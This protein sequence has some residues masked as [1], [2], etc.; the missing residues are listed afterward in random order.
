MF[1][2]TLFQYIIP[3]SVIL[4]THTKIIQIVGQRTARATTV[5]SSRSE[6]TMK[7]NKKTTKVKI[8]LLITLLICHLRRFLLQLRLNARLDPVFS[9]SSCLPKDARRYKQP[10]TTFC[11]KSSN[12][13]EHPLFRFVP[14]VQILQKFSV[15]TSA[16]ST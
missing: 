6:M 4:Y 5:T 15:R 8:K 14:R 12:M 10:S 11:H 3:I 9:F 1:R 2:F 13:L 16:N 7:R